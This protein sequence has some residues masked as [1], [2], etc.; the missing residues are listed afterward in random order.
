VPNVS[1]DQAKLEAKYS[2][3]NKEKINFV[4][5]LKNFVYA[6]S[7]EAIR[8]KVEANGGKMRFRLNDVDVELTLK[9][10]FFFNALDLAKQTG[11]DYE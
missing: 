8:R 10:D 7:K 11:T 3:F 5:D 2:Q 6:H 4:N 1:F 9:E